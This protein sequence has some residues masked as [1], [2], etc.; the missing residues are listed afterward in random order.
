MTRGLS[1]VRDAIALIHQAMTPGEF[2]LGATYAT[3]HTP[4]RRI[5]DFFAV[6]PADPAPDVYVDWLLA[7]CRRES[8]SWVWPQSRW[9]V[10]LDQQARFAAADVRLLLP[11]PDADTLD[12]IQDKNRANARLAAAGVPLPQTRSVATTDEFAEALVGLANGMGRACVKPARS[13]YGLGFR[14]IDDRKRPLD[15]FLT[16]DCFTIGSA[17]FA[18]LLA[19]ADGSRPSFLVMEY[20]AGDERSIDCLA[21]EGRLVRAVV[22]RKPAEAHGRWQWIETDPEAWEIARQAVAVLGLNGLVN[23]QTRERLHPDGRREQCF[24]EVNPRMSGGIDM[25]CRGGLN[26]PYWLLRLVAGTVGEADIPWA[27]SGVRVAKIE[28]AVVL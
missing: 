16:N 24:L 6:E 4:L 13:I 23:V 15:R 10:L 3:E 28:Q 12:I 25:A 17:E 27:I 1:N 19:S 2:H 22:R 9:A 26:L 8:F 5:A 18:A 20:L 7:L 21:W 11:C 14:L